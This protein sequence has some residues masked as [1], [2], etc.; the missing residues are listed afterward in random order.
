MQ[1]QEKIP[2]F[3]H[4]ERGWIIDAVIKSWVTPA[5]IAIKKGIKKHAHKCSDG[6][7]EEA[8]E[9]IDL[10]YSYKEA[11]EAT[12]RA[13]GDCNESGHEESTDESNTEEGSDEEPAEDEANTSAPKQMKSH[14]V[15]VRC[16]FYCVANFVSLRRKPLSKEWSQAVRLNQV[17]RKR[18]PRD[19]AKETP[20][21]RALP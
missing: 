19:Q 16:V 8:Y 21:K 17:P 14:E 15:F 18:M 6:P 20:R 11:S 5:S 7:N 10:L 13:Q 1:V 3:A 2:F 4:F 9:Y 12:K